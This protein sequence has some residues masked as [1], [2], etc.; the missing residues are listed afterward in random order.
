[1]T[2]T[3]ILG[4]A[5]SGKS[6]HAERLAAGSGDGVVYIA[7]AQARQDAEM[8]LRIAHHQADRPPH[9]LTVEEPLALAA[10]IRQWRT[11]G[12]VLIIDCLTLW[13]SNL[14]FTDHAAYPDVGAVALPERFH[15]ERAAMLDALAE[16]KGDV[17]MVSNE[18]GMGIVPM[19]AVVRCFMDEAGRLNQA[20]AAVADRVLFVA[21]GLPLVLKDC[22]AAA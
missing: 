1:M 9:W 10:M 8:A 2:I 18:I 11:P 13:L 21:A 14:I 7:T 15:A 22:K 6:A 20:V 16:G 4:G 17:I 19:G 5:R 12:R 3:L